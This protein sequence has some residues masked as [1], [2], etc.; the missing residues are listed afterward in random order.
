MYMTTENEAE[1]RGETRTI[2]FNCLKE[3][4]DG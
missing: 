1:Y 3:K 2:T 4:P